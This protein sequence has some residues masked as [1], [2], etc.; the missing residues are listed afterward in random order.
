MHAIIHA[1]VNNSPK[2]FYYSRE[3]KQLFFRVNN[4]QI[5]CYYSREKYKNVFLHE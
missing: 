2:T 1:S 4:S 3:N 5:K